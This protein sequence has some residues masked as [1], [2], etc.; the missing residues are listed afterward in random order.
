MCV[1]LICWAPL[2]VVM[3]QMIS[4]QTSSHNCKSAA[5]AFTPSPSRDNQVDCNFFLSA[6]RLASLNQIMDPWVYLLLREILLRKFCQ[7]ASAV[8]KCSIE[9]Q[10][11][12]EFEGQNEMLALDA[13]NK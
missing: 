6:I 13:L 9:V 10:N 8:S 4:T 7:A 12:T 3:L 5:V 1:L 2:L 11:K